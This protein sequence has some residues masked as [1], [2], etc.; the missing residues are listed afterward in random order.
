MRGFLHGLEFSDL[1]WDWYHATYF[2][3]CL[4]GWDCVSLVG[5]GCFVE[6]NLLLFLSQV[7]L[8]LPFLLLF[9]PFLLLKTFLF[10]DVQCHGLPDLPENFRNWVV[11]FFLHR[12]QIRNTSS[13]NVADECWFLRGL[14]YQQRKKRVWWMGFFHLAFMNTIF[15]W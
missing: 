3:H 9:V 4:P 10:L 7:T 12:T 5:L 14:I 13:V 6:I 15:I 11:I 1:D 8:S 2:A